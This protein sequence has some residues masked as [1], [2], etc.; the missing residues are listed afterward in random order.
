MGQDCYRRSLLN[1]VEI[2]PVSLLVVMSHR[3]R[4]ARICLLLGFACWAV[5]LP[6]GCITGMRT[7]SLRL[8]A[9]YQYELGDNARALQCIKRGV[10]SAAWPGV[11]VAVAIETYDDAGLYYFLSNQPHEAFVHQAVAVLLAETYPTP[12]NMRQV[13]RQRLKRALGACHDIDLAETDFDRDIKVL[14]AIGDVRQNPL[15]QRYY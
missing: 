2:G 15:V 9:Y 7:K 3:A 13:Y 12:E 8:D 1:L 14:L 4:P 10:R 11:P 6:T 5:L